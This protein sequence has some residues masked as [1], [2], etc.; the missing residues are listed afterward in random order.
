MTNRL[1]N[2]EPSRRFFKPLHICFKPHS[3]KIRTV[4]CTPK[5]CKAYRELP[6]SQFSQGI[7]C[8]HY[9]KPCSHCKDPVLITGTPV[10][11][12]TGLQC[13]LLAT[14]YIALVH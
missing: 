3:I 2:K 12:Y 4:H 9:R 8:F 14:T 13:K 5:P 6:V 11:P 10:L 1:A 7:T